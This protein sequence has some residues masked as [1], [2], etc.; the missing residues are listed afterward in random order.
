MFINDKGKIYLINMQME[1][2]FTGAK[3]EEQRCFNSIIDG[4]LILHDKNG[5]FIN[6]F[7]AFDIYFA[8]FTDLRTRPFIEVPY[9]NKKIFD[10]ACRLP[11][12][13]EFMTIL[14]PISIMTK[15]EKSKGNAFNNQR[16]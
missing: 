12:L 11:V 7:A 16:K 15:G 2:I 10:K 3:T 1:I 8:S 14:K 9:K 4:E 6:T 5:V 13:K